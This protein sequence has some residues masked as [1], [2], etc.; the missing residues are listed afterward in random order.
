MDAEL[1]L[2][3]YV[4]GREGVGTGAGPLAL[5]HCATRRPSSTDT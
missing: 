5:R 4:L 1:I 2:V 3:P